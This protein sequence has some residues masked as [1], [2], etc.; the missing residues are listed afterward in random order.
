MDATEV[1]IF[2]ENSPR[3][4]VNSEWVPATIPTDDEHVLHSP[5]IW[6]SR[7]FAKSLVGVD[8]FHDSI[9]PFAS[10]CASTAIH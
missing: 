9:Y 3:R 5:T 1:M 10:N 6:N 4:K 7:L 2:D 8:Q